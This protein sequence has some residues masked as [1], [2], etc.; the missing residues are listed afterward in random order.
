MRFPDMANSEA[1]RL[2]VMA[3]AQ[4]DFPG[5]DGSVPSLLNFGYIPK[6][7]AAIWVKYRKVA[8]GR[9]LSPVEPQIIIKQ[10]LIS[11]H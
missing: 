4:M 7:I 11:Q 5:L 6:A 1:A 2:A 3:G 10:V 9:L 8:A